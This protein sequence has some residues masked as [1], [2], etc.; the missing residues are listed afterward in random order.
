KRRFT[1]KLITWARTN[2]RDFPW[3]NS[4][5][6]Y[7]ILIAELLLQR[8]KASQV[9]PVY[10][11]FIDRFPSPGKLVNAETEEIESVI[12]SLGL[13]KKVPMI[14]KLAIEITENC[15]GKIPRDRKE[16][17]ALTGVG[18]YTANAVLCFAFGGSLPV[19]DWNVARVFKRLW[20]YPLKSAPHADKKFI[21][22][23]SGFIPEKN[24]RFLNFAILDFAALVCVP[25]KPYC[26]SCPVADICEYFN[27]NRITGDHEN[28]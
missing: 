10:E 11:R 15:G 28:T 4:D 18:H 9:Q 22:F 16:L 1:Y 12:R 7:N 21:E 23:V 19:V 2:G 26:E 17:L 25:R 6:P 27:L 20:K 3:R 5:N 24:A 13:L 8:T 14:K